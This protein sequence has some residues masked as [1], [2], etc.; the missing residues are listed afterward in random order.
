[1][2]NYHFFAF[3]LFLFLKNQAYSQ[4][5]ANAGADTTLCTGNSIKLNGSG[6]GIGALKYKWLTTG[7]GSFTPSDTVFNAVYNLSAADMTASV[8]DL[9]LQITDASACVTTDQRTITWGGC[10]AQ[11]LIKGFVFDDVNG[12]GIQDNGE[13]GKQNV[14]VNTTPVGYNYFGVTD[15]N[16]NYQIPVV[17]G[18]YIVKAVPS[19]NTAQ[20]FPTSNG[21]YTVTISSDTSYNNDFGITT[22]FFLDELSL[23]FSSSP[24]RPGFMLQ[25]DLHL[26]NFGT[27]TLNGNIL[28]EYDSYLTYINSNP[29]EDSHNSST[30]SL[31]FSYSNLD[32]GEEQIIRLFFTVSPSTPL[33]TEL[34]LQ[35]FPNTGG[36]YVYLIN[37]G[38]SFDPNEK[39]VDPI[40]IGAEHYI[41]SD[42]ILN[43]T[44]TFQNTGTDTAFT[45]IIRDTI[46]ADLDLASLK[47]IGASHDYSLSINKNHREII[48]TFDN[49][50]LPDSNRNEPLSHGYLTYRIKQNPGNIDGTEIKNKAGIYFDFN[51]PVITNETLNTVGDNVTLSLQSKSKYEHESII[52][53]PNPSKE[54]IFVKASFE[55]QTYSIYSTSGQKLKEGKFDTLINISDLQEGVY[56][57]NF[58]N[59]SESLYEKIIVR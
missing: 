29:A 58:R 59:N 21:T 10:P 47:M 53:Y 31:T 44:V 11:G 33:G 3:I 37:V 7:T 23:F 1:M 26:K 4:C 15:T 45:V 54:F 51:V 48:C 46:D 43:Y 42:D 12:N 38:G 19:S 22:L 49:I 36:G 24:A 9:A 41:Y 17:N 35:A 5:S 18:T 2:R 40:G 34:E 8:F 55:I 25:Y 57:I 20:T 52:I 30:R 50:L 32:P 28:L 16:G 6:S 14:L 27:N 39:V 56:F 13:L